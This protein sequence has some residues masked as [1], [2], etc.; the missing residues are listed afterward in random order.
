MWRTGLLMIGVLLFAVSEVRAGQAS[1][2]FSVGIRIGPSEDESLLQ[3]QTTAMTYTRGAAAISVRRAG[4]D[5]PVATGRSKDL[6]WFTATRGGERFRVA[7][8]IFSGQIVR[9]LPSRS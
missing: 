9:V 3:A 2:S 1:S 6:Y 7:V 5:A 8:S 4:F